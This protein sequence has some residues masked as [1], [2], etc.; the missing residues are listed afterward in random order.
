M[1]AIKRKRISKVKL[2]LKTYKKKFTNK[3][4]KMN[5]P[6][7]IKDIS[8]RQAETKTT[9]TN[10]S[11]GRQWVHMS[12][13]DIDA[14]PW[15]TTQGLTNPDGATN[16][17]SN[18]SNRIGDEILA[19]GVRYKIFLENNERFAEVHHR[20]IF[21]KCARGQTITSATVFMGRS[22]NK[23]IDDIARDKITV[24]YDRTF[25]LKGPNMITG[26]STTLG[27]DDYEQNTTSAVGTG[28]YSNNPAPGVVSHQPGSKIITLY[29]PYR[30]DNKY[31]KLVYTADGGNVPKFYDYH[32]LYMPY[33]LQNTSD[34]LNVSKFNDMQKVFYFKDP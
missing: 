32:L 25:K 19:K 21:I 26:A 1:P 11:D 34:T 7:M 6:K 10:Y 23:L 20:F 15:S 28:I 17:S 30:K 31:H 16:N 12:L 33:V 22:D 9:V 24:L 27:G 2:G 3:R 13:N 5:I 4:R 14:A 8:V 18:Q 29:F